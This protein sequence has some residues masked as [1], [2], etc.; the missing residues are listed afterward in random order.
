MDFCVPQKVF[1]VI[2]LFVL[3]LK[4]FLHKEGKF[5]KYFYV[6]IP[7]QPQVGGQKAILSA[8]HLGHLASQVPGASH[9]KATLNPFDNTIY[10]QQKD[11]EWEED[12]KKGAE[13]E[14]FF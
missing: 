11:G 9:T 12:H 4:K 10:D 13:A 14:A 3:F 6:S 8:Q 7:N 1:F 2:L 5:N